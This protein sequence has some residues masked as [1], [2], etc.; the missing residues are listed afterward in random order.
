MKGK[1]TQ[2]ALFVSHTQM[3]TKMRMKKKSQLSVQT[4]KTSGLKAFFLDILHRVQPS[5]WF[6]HYSESKSWWSSFSIVC[7]RQSSSLVHLTTSK[8][9]NKMWN[10]DFWWIWICLNMCQELRTKRKKHSVPSVANTT[11][12]SVFHLELSHTVK[13]DEDIST[14]EVF[15]I[16]QQLVRS[17]NLTGPSTVQR[18]F[19]IVFCQSVHGKDSA[20]AL[21]GTSLV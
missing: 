9:L 18:P 16:K 1:T 21:F 4:Q 5:G 19:F 10:T 8:V 14:K 11:L 6:I 7:E 13:R 20:L 12:T 17:S 3:H 2:F 15:I